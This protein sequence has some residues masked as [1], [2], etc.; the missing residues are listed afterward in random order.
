MGIEPKAFSHRFNDGLII[1]FVV[2][3]SLLVGLIFPAQLLGH[4]GLYR[5]AL[6]LPSIILITG[7][8]AWASLRYGMKF[9]RAV[10]PP[11]GLTGRRAWLDTTIGIAAAIVLVL[12][13]LM[14][15]ARWPFSSISET[16]DWDAGAY[17]LPKA[18]ELLN[19]GS[20]WDFTISYGEYPFGYESL[21]SAAAMLDR[22][23]YLFGAAHLLAVLYFVITFWFLARRFGQ[24]PAGVS[25]FF[26]AALVTAG[27]FLWGQYTPWFIYRYLI[28]TIGKNDL[29]LGAT[30][31][32]VILHAPIGPRPLQR[33]WFPLGMAL[34]TFLSFSTKPNGMLTAAPLWGIAL[35]Y[36]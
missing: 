33:A 19:T 10:L 16:L 35:I 24:L 8:T 2:L 21:F 18:L 12:L 36:F 30:L 28:Y 32:A 15:V 22:R 11:P 5:A 9:Y 14:P 34:A 13:I 29:F 26:V 23:G 6:V 3:Q 4:M 7:I 20:V 17:H 27:T 31:L 25:L 1:F